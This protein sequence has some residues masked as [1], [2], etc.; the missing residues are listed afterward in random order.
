MASL[1]TSLLNSANAIDVMDHQLAVVQNNVSNANTPGY[2]RQTQSVQA[3]ALE[4]DSGL[5]GG[6]SAGPVLSARS[7][8]AEETVRRQNSLVGAAEQ[9]SADLA[10][11]EPLFDL[12]SAS[13]ISNTLNNF[14]QS[15]SQLGV[16][17]NDTV[18]RQSV[19]DQA[20]TVAQAFQQTATGLAKARDNASVGI[21]SV[22]SQINDL[23]A[24]IAKLN[25]PRISDYRNAMDPGADAQMHAALENLSELA[26]ITVLQDRNGSFNVYLG[27]QAPLVI[28]GHQFE[29][30]AGPSTSATEVLDPEGK[31]VSGM[32]H[33]GK[34]GGL[35]DEQ[36]NTIPEY[37]AQLDQLAT[38]FADAVNNQLKTGLDA[39]GTTPAVD[40]FS[41]NAAA[42]AISLAVTSIQP[43][44][45]AAASAGA[46]GGNGNALDVAALSDQKLAGSYTLTQFYGNLASRVGQDISSSADE[47]QSQQSLVAQA[48]NMRS[49]VSG[50]SLDE[51]ATVM[52]QIQRQYQA[53]G[54]VIGVLDELT[55]TLL[56]MVK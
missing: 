30:T 18:S 3:L 52:M 25:S 15:F 28:G 38:T 44:Q 12:N 40:L 51:E 49:D 11:I 42:P 9:R 27:G 14:F 33:C 5:L 29:L 39:N 10:E 7:E 24:Q 4:P 34:L 23:S 17:P 16:N 46:P 53:A 36:R 20:G 26:N 21:R 54:K 50:V 47:Q 32:V 1:L 22:L 2:A 43:D 45:I 48:R 55:D 37:Q 41:Y 8:Y 19:I 35:I 13:S 56:S 6:V 31:D